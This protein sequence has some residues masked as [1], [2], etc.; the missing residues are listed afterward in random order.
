MQDFR[1]GGFMNQKKEKV[2]KKPSLIKKWPF[3][4][5]DNVVISDN[6]PVLIYVLPANMKLIVTEFNLIGPALPPSFT[7]SYKI[8]ETTYTNE[9]KYWNT[10]RLYDG[11]KLVFPPEYIIPEVYKRQIKIPI[12][13]Y[14][15]EVV[16]KEQN[17]PYTFEY[18]I[19]QTLVFKENVKIQFPNLK[20]DN[21]DL[22]P[23]I[24]RII[25]VGEMIEQIAQPETKEYFDRIQI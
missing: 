18:L 9:L 13:G 3:R 1:G 21:G 7:F 12:D 10:Y 11:T 15:E 23:V 17:V 4:L 19:T 5:T 22:F 24:V 8:D 2:E 6:N 16:R 20:L 14:E 25:M